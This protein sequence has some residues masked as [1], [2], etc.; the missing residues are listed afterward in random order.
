MLFIVT[1]PHGVTETPVQ[2]AP[3]CLGHIQKA[4]SKLIVLD[5]SNDCLLD[6]RRL[7]PVGKLEPQPQTRLTREGGRSFDPTALQRQVHEHLIALPSGMSIYY[8]LLHDD[9]STNS[10]GHRLTIFPEDED[11]VQQLYLEGLRST[12]PKRSASKSGLAATIGRRGCQRRGL[13]AGLSPFLH[14]LINHL[15]GVQLGRQLRNA[16]ISLSYF[17]LERL[18]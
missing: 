1:E 14:V 15:E 17:P 13:S 16:L 10:L 8:P 5:P 18:H 6:L 9:T 3:E 12:R 7:C 4:Y 11:P 2:R